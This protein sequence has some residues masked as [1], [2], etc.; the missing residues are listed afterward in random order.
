MGRYPPPAAGPAATSCEICAAAPASWWDHLEQRF[1]L[2]ASCAV[3]LGAAVPTPAGLVPTGT[4]PW[5]TIVV[6]T[7]ASI[8]AV[9]A[10]LTGSLPV[11]AATALL[12]TAPLVRPGQKRTKELA[13]LWG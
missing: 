3:V 11:V 4:A 6:C 2:C 13:P 9:A 12:I 10:A 1:E 7:L 5:S 8:G